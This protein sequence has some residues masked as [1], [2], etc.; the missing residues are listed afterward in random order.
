MISDRIKEAINNKGIS[1]SDV[2][3]KAGI[4]RQQFSKYYHGEAI[5]RSDALAKIAV[6]LGV[7]SDY[8]LEIEQKASI[9]SVLSSLLQL[10]SQT[11]TLVSIDNDI[12]PAALVIRCEDKRIVKAY[13]Q[14]SI[15]KQQ[16]AALTDNKVVT[17]ILSSA[18]DKLMFDFYNTPLED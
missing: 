2:A 10:E 18:R 12:P 16:I 11:E 7:S 8:L 9:G 15:L 1:Q 5:P 14:I 6:A 13:E 4:S 17:D 3:D